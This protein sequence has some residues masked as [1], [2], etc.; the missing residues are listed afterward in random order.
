MILLMIGMSVIEDDCYFHISP[1][2]FSMF[3]TQSLPMLCG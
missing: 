3:F 1:F 2:I